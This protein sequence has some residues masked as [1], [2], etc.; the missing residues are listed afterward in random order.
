MS[1]L[2]IAALAVAIAFV[3]ASAV[4]Y[5]R[6]GVPGRVIRGG[7]WSSSADYARASYLSWYSSAYGSSNLGFRVARGQSGG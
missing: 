1:P 2:L 4:L 5:A 7:G 3:I 6:A